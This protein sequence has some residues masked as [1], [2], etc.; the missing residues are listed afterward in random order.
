ML[1]RSQ[2][3]VVWSNLLA[4]LDDAQMT[5]HDVVSVTTYVVVDHMASLGQVMAAR[6][7]ALGG[8]R[9]AST[10]VTVPALARPE[11]KMEIALVAA[12]AEG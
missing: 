1:F 11:W 7:R 10:L 6:D 12:Y 3:E 4:M 9:V 8:R 5:V 2:A